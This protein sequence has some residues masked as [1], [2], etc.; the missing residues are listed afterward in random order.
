MAAE[1]LAGATARHWE[2]RV[3]WKLH[4]LASRPHDPDLLREATTLA[5]KAAAR[6]APSRAMLET[7][8]LLA[9]CDP[10]PETLVSVTM[11]AG[12]GSTG[13]NLPAQITRRLAHLYPGSGI[14]WAS[15]GPQ[16]LPHPAHAPVPPGHVAS[17]TATTPAGVKP[18]IALTTRSHALAF[19]KSVCHKGLA[20]DP[21][22]PSG[23][24]ALVSSCLQ[25][26]Q[27]QQQQVGESGD[28]VGALITKAAEWAERG[29]TAA[30]ELSAEMG[31]PC[32]RQIRALRLLVAK[33][34]LANGDDVSLERA[35]G[36][37]RELV[38]EASGAGDD[39]CEA[40]A[41][42]GLA[43]AL[44]MRSEF[45]EAQAALLD[46]LSRSPDDAWALSE[47]GWLKYKLGVTDANAVD[48]GLLGEA[49]TLL[50]RAV[51]ADGSVPE[52]H[53][54]L[55]HIVWSLGDASGADKGTAYRHWLTAAKLAPTTR[56]GA[57]SLEWIGRYYLTEARDATRAKACFQKALTIDPC[58]EGAGD[59]LADMLEASQQRVA[60]TS[61]LL[62]I[63]DKCPV[64]YWA[65]RRL[66]R[67]QLSAGKLEDATTSL[68]TSLKGQPDRA[69]AWEGLAC[70]YQW[71]G[72][73][74][75][76]LKA[77]ARALQG[78]PGRLFCV[79]QSAS[80]LFLLGKYS[81]ALDSFHRILEQ[82]PR[83]LAARAGAAGC[84]LA[85]AQRSVSA[86]A[87]RSAA[88]LLRQA[89][90]LLQ[91][92]LPSFGRAE[93]LWKMLGDILLCHAST[94][95]VLP[96]GPGNTT[97]VASGA[98]SSSTLR[99]SHPSGMAPRAPANDPGIS[100]NV[101]GSAS[102][103]PDKAGGATTKTGMPTDAA[104]GAGAVTRPNEGAATTCPGG[105]GS[106]SVPAETRAGMGAFLP[107]GRLKE[108]LG[109]RSRGRQALLRQ[110]RRAYARGM[111]AN[112][113]RSG[114]W[115]DM[116]LA[117]HALA[118][119]LEQEQEEG[120]GGRAE[121]A[122]SQLSHLAERL[123][124]AGVLMD[125]GASWES[126]NVLGVL[127]RS[128]P[129]RQHALIRAV[130]V[131]DSCGPAW[132]N[133]GQLYMD[134]GEVDLAYQAFDKARSADPDVSIPWAAMGLMVEEETMG[135]ETVR[136]EQEALDAYTHAIDMWQGPEAMLG[137]AKL[138][139]RRGN[140]HAPEAYLAATKAAA[141]LPDS[142]AA[143]NVLGLAC[144]LLARPTASGWTT[145]GARP[146]LASAVDAFQ[147]S[148]A[149]LV[150]RESTASTTAANAPV[151]HGAHVGPHATVSDDEMGRQ[152]RPVAVELRR[153][154]AGAAMGTVADVWMPGSA[155]S[156]G[157]GAGTGMDT[158]AQGATANSECRPKGIV[159]LANATQAKGEAAGASASKYSS[160][161][162]YLSPSEYMSASGH[163]S[164]S[165]Y[166][167]A[168]MG[169]GSEAAI[170]LASH[171]LEA[172]A[173]A[174][175]ARALLKA[176]RWGDA[177]E[178]YEWLGCQ[179]LLRGDPELLQGYSLA[180]LCTATC[181]PPASTPP[182]DSATSAPTQCCLPSPSVALF[183]E[184]A[185]AALKAAVTCAA[186]RLDAAAVTVA[187]LPVEST[188]HSAPS[189]RGPASLPAASTPPHTAP[190]SDS[191][192]Q[193]TCTPQPSQS[194]TASAIT[195]SEPTL[196]PTLSDGSVN[197]PPPPAPLLP[198]G[199][200]P[201]E[202]LAAAREA[203]LSLLASAVQV[204]FW[205]W[206]RT[207]HG[208]G[209][210]HDDIH[211]SRHHQSGHGSVM[212]GLLGSLSGSILGST[213]S[214]LM[215]DPHAGGAEDPDTTSSLR[216]HGEVHKVGTPST[217]KGYRVPVEQG[218][219]L[220]AASN[221]THA[222][223]AASASA[224][225]E[226]PPWLMAACRRHLGDGVDGSR[227]LWL[228]ILAAAALC[229]P[230]AC[231]GFG[232]VS[233]GGPTVP[234]MLS[235]PS[236]MG[237]GSAP[238][239]SVEPAIPTPH[240]VPL[241]FVDKPGNPQ[242]PGGGAARS[243]LME[244]AV[245][246]VMTRWPVDGAIV[247]AR[248][249]LARG[250]AKRATRLLARALHSWPSHIQD[251]PLRCTL[252]QAALCSAAGSPSLAESAQAVLRLVPP[253][254][255]LSLS[256]S[257]SVPMGGAR[258]GPMGPRL[259]GGHPA[260]VLGPS[261]Y[262]SSQS[263]PQSLLELLDMIGSTRC[264]ATMACGRTVLSATERPQGA[265]AGGPPVK[266]SDIQTATGSQA[267]PVY[268]EALRWLHA[269]PNSASAR[270]A[271]AALT[272]ARRKHCQ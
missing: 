15:L 96:P 136:S 53:I 162:D 177:G 23:W 259:Q 260:S 224:G 70:C 205:S 238:G 113:A 184:L 12:F 152:D 250:Q 183:L 261:G 249:W 109:A 13:S 57:E 154:L 228:V 174:N 196:P 16:L 27:K 5:L 69:D 201:H 207:H 61:I 262:T 254:G 141:A 233:A 172:V 10:G 116:A 99:L 139:I 240:T 140:G 71:R 176:G 137:F 202:Q 164:A 52:C 131:N 119:L 271:L 125:G 21:R 78:D 213:V 37:F 44:V 138:S 188:P 208:R 147:T 65:W 211:S 170:S 40:A 272:A 39:A 94:G 66:G 227:S 217:G 189:L 223:A 55:G 197:R 41:R 156:T 115:A 114:L 134:Q 36:A 198:S 85:L 81:E 135:V 210:G 133:L 46:I 160:V 89:E 87:P 132:C 173:T 230:E 161:A 88:L 247:L 35:V 91:A 33:C 232:S 169:D 82:Q 67:L 193:G 226:L 199:E 79:H 106:A 47:L 124:W 107:P 72:M 266:S 54:R 117:T 159:T 225:L 4:Q 73:Y 20:W 258:G 95:V 142:A 29:L 194:V 38:T 179:G 190:R 118:R 212:E 181:P 24:A 86:G 219:I 28:H 171:S 215:L 255:F 51:A 3:T 84:L 168:Y 192:Q 155:V 75:S 9:D 108:E 98:A 178:A 122:G 218:G 25:L 256:G 76:A 48:A 97:P 253:L 80:I 123:A 6:P 163:A 126:W 110:S 222:A 182:Q 239:T 243:E 180:L 244:E 103:L 8:L 17:S 1:I 30:R 49:R 7:L 112:P 200:S 77:Y 264:A 252:G 68:R 128:T 22:L 42:K 263:R 146:L 267:S 50:E 74:T 130:Q 206:Q 120:E 231:C 175:L 129:L 237:E 59:N 257:P 236:L 234:V 158:G 167:S 166:I 58:R 187:S 63:C 32:D 191:A 64:A 145:A 204:L 209:P 157:A 185:G 43:H 165:E 56:G 60:L 90:D 127:A 195:A 148:R 245:G 34:A 45:N 14:A 2:R 151:G 121:G 235:T 31:L 241:E 150:E 93:S 216:T 229:A 220:A 26:A 19:T 246:A 62:D 149:L 242:V 104:T 269:C 111:H 18:K 102:M 153:T 186:H 100:D 265:Q 251:L 221:G 214:E 105:Q 92:C 83:H 144:E 203:L 11:P 143:H 101:E 248:V 268:R 270:R